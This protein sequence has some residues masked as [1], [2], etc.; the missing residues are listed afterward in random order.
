MGGNSMK[1]ALVAFAAGVG[2]VV[3]LCAVMTAVRHHNYKR[4]EEQVR[5][6]DLEQQRQRE[7]CLA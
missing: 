3:G 1:E 5:Q 4:M 2:V 7:H 6:W